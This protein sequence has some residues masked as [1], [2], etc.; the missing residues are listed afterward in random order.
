[1]SSTASTRTPLPEGTI[2]VAAALL[3]AGVATYAFFKVGTWALGRR[4]R[5][6]A[7]LV[8][9][10]RDVRTGA[11][12]LPA[13]RAGARAGPGPP[14]RRRPGRAPGRRQGHPPRPACCWASSSW[15]SSPLSPLIASRLLRRRLGHGRGPDRRVRR[16]RPGAPRPR[17]L[18]G[19][20]AGSSRTPSSWARDGRRPH[21]AVR[22]AGRDRRHRRRPVRVRRRRSPRCSASASSA[23]AAALR[24]EPGP[25]ATWSEVTPNLGWLLLGSVFAAALLNAGPI[26]TTLL[27]DDPTRTPRSPQFAYGVLL[28][29]IPL[30]MFQAVQAALLPRLTRLA[31]RGEL[32]EF[33][34]GLRRLMIVVA[35]RRRRR[36][37][38]RAGARPVGDRAGVRRRSDRRDAGHAGARQRALH[39][40]AGPRPGRHRAQGPRP[41]GAR[42]GRSASSPSCSPRGCRATTCSAGSR[43]ACCWP[44]VAAMVAFALALRHRSTSASA[45]DEDS[46]HGGHHRHALRNLISVAEDS[47]LDLV[48]LALAG[49]RSTCGR[50]LAAA[51]TLGSCA[52]HIQRT[53]H[54]RATPAFFGLGR[55]SWAT[56]ILTS[57]GKSTS[58]CQPSSVRALVASPISRSTSAGRKNFG[59]WRT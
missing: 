6:Q 45:P 39:G 3:I 38:R 37:A 59:S 25:E 40:G 17:R 28:A 53:R 29:R 5:V 23:P 48:S 36:H 46:M 14:P 54:A 4:R 30:F 32:D 58:G 31:A 56:I 34:G 10:V 52:A 16:L 50:K 18:L 35:R 21:R 2:P 24:T 55:R 27:A 22:A 11:R 12:L 33:R 43:S 47:L 19:H 20:R 1:M 7:D 26:A 15:P 13:A 8:P 42:L 41:R 51:R 44:S 57:V 9:V 49:R